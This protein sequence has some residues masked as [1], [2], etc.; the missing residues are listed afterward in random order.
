M[1]NFDYIS[2]ARPLFSFM[3]NVEDFD[4]QQGPES[5]ENILKQSESNLSA[6]RQTFEDDGFMLAVMLLNAN[7]YGLPQARKRI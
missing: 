6:L 1:A 2:K 3:E 5:D 7:Q 4:D